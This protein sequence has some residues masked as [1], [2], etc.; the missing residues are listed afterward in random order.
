MSFAFP[1]SPFDPESE[2]WWTKGTSRLAK[3]ICDI[4]LFPRGLRVQMRFGE[5]TRA[6]LRMIRLELNAHEAKCDWV[7]RSADPWDAD[8][9]IDIGRRHASLQA[10]QDA[11]DVRQLLF[12]VLP[13]VNVAHLRIYRES[14]NR[15][16]EMI[17]SG[18]VHRNTPSFRR[19][20]STAMRAK[21]LGFRFSL[22]DEI[23]CGRALE[24]PRGLPA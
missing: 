6:P 7:A 12:E 4:G 3:R 16:R 1:I 19:V 15:G 18:Q 22:E 5:L 23:L 13:D 2:H 14:S 21:L 10:L 8:L 9:P 17:I 11:L 20:R 24:E